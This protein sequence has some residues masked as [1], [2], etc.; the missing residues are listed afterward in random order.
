[1][2]RKCT[3]LDATARRRDGQPAAVQPAQDDLG[4]RDGEPPEEARGGE[5]QER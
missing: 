1:M 4:Q 5:R 3:R 2:T